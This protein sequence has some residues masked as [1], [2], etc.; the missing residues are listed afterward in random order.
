MLL[1]PF[2]IQILS[3]TFVRDGL[4]NP[5]LFSGFN[6]PKI[7]TKMVYMLSYLRRDNLDIFEYKIRDINSL[8]ELKTFIRKLLANES[9]LGE[10]RAFLNANNDL[11]ET[12]NHYNGV[13]DVEKSMIDT[14]TKMSNVSNVNELCNLIFTL[15]EKLGRDLC[16]DSTS[17]ESADSFFSTYM[18]SDDNVRTLGC[19]LMTWINR[20]I[21]MLSTSGAELYF[22]STFMF[23]VFVDSTEIF[24]DDISLG[25]PTPGTS[26]T[27]GQ[28]N[29]NL[30]SGVILSLLLNFDKAVGNPSEASTT[31]DSPNTKTKK[32][33][34]KKNDNGSP[35]LS[36]GFSTLANANSNNV[37]PNREYKL[38]HIIHNCKVV[39]IVVPSIFKLTRQ[40]VDSLD[41][42]LVS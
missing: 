22:N 17:F 5:E 30:S 16:T 25:K 27:V 10:L 18:K 40:A 31:N 14:L 12:F 4:T 2:F 6:L 32:R 41:F 39:P 1:F 28:I 8:N 13:K 23:R 21:G 19:R 11:L 35:T 15:M 29:M 3:S 9:F 26:D 37:Q 42:S 36:R 33:S 24:V 7:F 38:I 20:D 34:K